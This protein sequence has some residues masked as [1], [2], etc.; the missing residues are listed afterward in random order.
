MSVRKGEVAGPTRLLSV[1]DLADVLQVPVTTVYEWRYRGEGP[2]A[3]RVG[4]YVRFDPDDVAR[5]VASR[6]ER[7]GKPGGR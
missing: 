6:R 4:K 1:K 2:E 5:W 7:P 3:I